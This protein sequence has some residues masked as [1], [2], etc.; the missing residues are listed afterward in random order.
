MGR[1]SLSI[2]QLRWLLLVN[3]QE[4][5]SRNLRIVM[6]YET[7]QSSIQMGLDFLVVLGISIREK[8]SM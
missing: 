3:L 7:L 5:N 8:T 2:S 1:F 4:E 6:R